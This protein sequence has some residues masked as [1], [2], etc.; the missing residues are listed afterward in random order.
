[1]NRLG[2]SLIVG[3]IAAAVVWLAADHGQAGGGAKN[4]FQPIVPKEIYKELVKREAMKIEESLGKADGVNRAKLGALLIIAYTKSIKDGA[5]EDLD[6][7]ATTATALFNALK[8]KDV[9]KAKKLAGDLTAGN[10]KTTKTAILKDLGGLVDKA[11]LMDHF[12]PLA[13]GGDGM[14]PD[15]QSNIKFKGALNGIEEKIRNL[16]M[17]ELTPERMKKEAKELQML[18]YRTAVAGSLTY[19]YAPAKKVGDKNPDDWRRYSVA[20][21]DSAVELAMAAAKGDTAAVARAGN[22]LNSACSQCHTEFR[23]N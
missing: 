11:D 12:R 6:G 10:T 8:E 7:T 20:M 9:D 17:K 18:A 22:T 21:R 19:L 5:G 23:S 13:K 1:M 2:R 14:H 16:A 3:V 4:P 15:L